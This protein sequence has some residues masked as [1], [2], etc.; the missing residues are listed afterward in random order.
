MHGPGHA[1]H[2]GGDVPPQRRGTR[3][4]TAIARFCVRRAR[5][6]LGAWAL[7]LLAA[8]AIG[9]S[10]TDHIGQPSLRI[11]G[12][13]SARAD[14]LTRKAFG[15]TI[16]MAVLLKGP[17]KEVERRGP[18]LVRELQQIEG[19]H[20]LSP[21]AI[22]GERVLREPAGQALLALQVSRPFDEISQQTTPAVQDAIAR[23]VRAPL[24]ARITGLA[25]LVRALNESSIDSLH[26]GELLALPILFVML[27]L[28]FGSPVAALVPALSGML[29][30]QVGI[31]ALGLVAR[32]IH[33]DALAL[34]LVTM[35][36]LA[37]GV[38]YAL[39][40]VSRFREE[41]DGG[42]SV[43]EAAQ[44]AG[45][46]AGRTVLIA[47]GALIL[48]MG[49]GMLVAP[50]S[51]LVSSGIGVVVAALV[52]MAIAMLAMP[53]ALALLG[54]N[55]NRW[56]LRSG[57]HGVYW[58]RLSR[59][60]LRAPGLAALLVLVPLALMSAP[61]LA[62][63]TGPPDVANLPAD[64]EARKSYEAFERDRGAGWSTPYEVVFQTDGPITTTERLRALRRFQDRAATLQGAEAV[65]G[66]A[67]L[68]DRTAVLRSLTR[69]L[70][71]ADRQV[72]RLEHGLSR[73]RSGTG[74][75]RDGLKSGAE[76]AGQLADGLGRAAT[77]AGQ[78]AQGTRDAAPQTSRL[79]DGVQRT[80]DGSRRLSGALG[81]AREGT[82]KIETNLR[83]LRDSLV[84]ADRGSDQNLS[85]PVAETQSAV[86][87][88]LRNLGSIGDPTVSGNPGV[89]RAKADIARALAALGPL[90][91][92]IAN[93][94]TDLGTNATASKELASAVSE[95]AD[96][97]ERMA[98][99]SD[100]LAGGIDR[101]A[102]GARA[103]AQG[104][105]QLTTGTSQLS[106]GLDLLVGGPGGDDGARAL[107]EGLRRAYGGSN[108]IGRALARML[109]SVVRVRTSNERRQ[110]ELRRG[111][112]DVRKAADSGFFVLAAVEGAGPQ[113]QTNVG[114]ATNA[115]SGGNT[116][117]V[118]VVPREG[119]FSERSADLRP[120]LQRE[121]RR[122]A[123]A[124]GATAIV[125]GPAVVL[126]DFDQATSERFLL[127][128]AVLSLVT[129][130]VL[131]AAFRA[132]ALA[133]LAV[134]LNL[135][136]V[137]AALGVLVLCFGGDDPLLGGSG[138][139]DAIALMGIFAIVFGLSIDY[140]VFFMSRLVEGRE[141]T[142]TTDGAIEHGLEKTTG[143][144]TGAAFI[145]AAVFLAFAASPVMNTR[146]FGVGTTVAVLLDATV[147]RLLLLPALVKLLGERTWWVPRRMRGRG[148]ASGGAATGAPEEPAPA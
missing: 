131:L 108:E 87:S 102:A 118:I 142:G 58:Q 110:D 111:G 71:G 59:R 19:V 148:G 37:L 134:L 12:S 23:T 90:K 35:V 47:G 92:N 8:L 103:L 15:G 52:A 38:D 91:T 107:A 11:P 113:T 98:S 116:A 143:I 13:D 79:A 20:V 41:L 63:K 51:L 74:R 84:D 120:A 99:G 144:I 130:L 10:T 96:G 78:L 147:V 89:Q 49:C 127:L 4:V 106:Q 85:E 18:R 126:D 29:V 16:S 125:G 33:I 43:A 69:E 31:A 5:L 76:G 65:L 26:R 22:G 123:R 80:A 50:G 40:V 70:T 14:D 109:D 57:R 137:G 100:E 101:T 66:P 97:L 141:L 60:A 145:M 104:V 72:R 117:R 129:F 77:G 119:P 1:P 122:T 95:L 36:G 81:Q 114:F 28:I 68:L 62:L 135:V 30:I 17:A 121:A 21:W 54:T 32:E 139:L 82:N 2:P 55:V 133:A 112:T 75:L 86:Q 24:Q 61:A 124:I 53:A 67:A 44:E 42:M 140:E 25:P 146:Q 132:P 128:V 48:G 3:A 39:L 105:G 9:E 64:D 34:N 45:V 46:R 83:V 88:A 56:P 73:T 27:L 6:V 115:R 7:L 138:E 136:T 94:A 93:Y